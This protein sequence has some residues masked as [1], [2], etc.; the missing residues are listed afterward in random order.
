MPRP[1]WRSTDADGG[2]VNRWDDLVDR[3]LQCDIPAIFRWNK[4]LLGYA[5]TCRDTSAA[6]RSSTVGAE[7]VGDR[8]RAYTH[9]IEQ[10]RYRFERV[11]D[12]ARLSR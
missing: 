6:L 12:F 1:N 2:V 7:R 4:I 11:T 8:S 3:Y 5:M 9:A 10:L